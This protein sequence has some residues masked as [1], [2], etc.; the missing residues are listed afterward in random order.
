MGAS[1]GGSTQTV[2]KSDP[3]EGAQPFLK[4]VFQQSQGLYQSGA[5]GNLPFPASSPINTSRRNG[6]P[7]A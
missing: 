3:W 6:G 7:G 5:L 2:Q 4:D 1:G